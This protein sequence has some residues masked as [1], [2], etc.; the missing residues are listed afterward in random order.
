[1]NIDIEIESK[2]MDHLGIISGVCDQI[3]L[4]ESI[5]LIIPKTANMNLSVGQRIKAMI[6]NGLGF[7]GRPLY[8]T[9]EFF[10][11]KPTEILLGEGVVADDLND[12]ALGRALDA[13]YEA[14]AEFIFAKVAS[15]AIEVCK[16]IVGSA[17]YD[18]TS[19]SLEG[20]YDSED[21]DVQIVKFGYSKDMR[22]DLKQIILG[23]LAC[24]SEGIPLI[25]KILPGNTSDAAHFKETLKTLQYNA[26][27]QNPDFRLVFDAAG[28]NIETIK[29]LCGTKW[30]SRVPCT[31]QEAQQLKNSLS[32]TSFVT[33][34]NGYS[35]YETASNYGNVNQRWVVVHS[36]KALTRE[37]KTIDRVVLKAE[38][39]VIKQIKKLN[40]K[41]F[42]CVNDAQDAVKELEKKQKYHKLS[43]TNMQEKKAFSD[44][45]KPKKDANFSLKFSPEIDFSRDN[46]KIEQVIKNKSI[47]IVATNDFDTENFPGKKVLK[48]YK[49]QYRVERGFRFLKNPL[50]MARSIYL[51]NQSRIIALGVV[52]FLCLLVYAIAE[53]SL[54]KSLV[55]HNET[56]KN[57]VKKSVQNPTMRWIFQKME[58]VMVLR[59]KIGDRL[60]T[61]I[62]NLTDE[63][64]KIITLLG[65][66][67]MSKYL[68]ITATNS[69]LT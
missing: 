36:E 2:G 41:N 59:Y 25:V 61:K 38:K 24:G 6:I 4:V 13:L 56:V 39:E 14:N 37:K 62:A 9:K 27:G 35:I 10:N 20:A 53:H 32:L 28:Y 63:L 60:I 7:T 8:I 17:H 23:S 40:N 33:I 42:A 15:K 34:E 66:E 47:F 45:G 1:M 30:I 65:Q 18:T 21:G 68:L 16:I 48:E 3:K 52:M 55:K 26:F 43:I 67:C 19:M 11:T 31:I 64:K 69:T 50:C 57:Q 12:D 58:D 22:S 46:E 29:S 49:N 54:R 44:K 51:K 5:D